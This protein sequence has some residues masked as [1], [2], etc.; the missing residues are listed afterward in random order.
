MQYLKVT[1]FENTR[2][3]KIAADAYREELERLLSKADT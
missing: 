3:L 2:F 1:E